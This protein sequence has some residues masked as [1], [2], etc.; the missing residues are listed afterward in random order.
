MSGGSDGQIYK[1]VSLR[2]A[3]VFLFVKIALAQMYTLCGWTRGS[4]LVREDVTQKEA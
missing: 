3:S 2:Y 4:S 1:G